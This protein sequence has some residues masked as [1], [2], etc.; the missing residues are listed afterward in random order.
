MSEKSEEQKNDFSQTE[1]NHGYERQ[2]LDLENNESDSESA[3]SSESIDSEESKKCQ[4]NTQR[5][6]KS[7][8]KVSV[9]NP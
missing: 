2:Q 6:R 4:I 9:Q 7:G 5:K 8:K 3:F 1:E